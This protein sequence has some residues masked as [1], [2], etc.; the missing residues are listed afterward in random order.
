MTGHNR[1]PTKSPLISERRFIALCEAAILG[2][3]FAGL[4]FLVIV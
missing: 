4:L 1:I 3:V 2:T